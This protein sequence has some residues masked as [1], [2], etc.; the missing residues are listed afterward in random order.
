[1]PRS[2]LGPLAI[3][4][5]LGDH[6]SQSSV[7]RAIH[8]EQKRPIAVKIFA[9]PF[10]GTL[11]SRTQ[12]A[13]EWD[14]LKSLSHPAIVRCYG[15]GFEKTDAYLAHELIEGETLSAELQR[16]TR[17]SWESVLEIAEPI[18]DALEY[19]H[20][21]GIVH[22]AIGPEKIMIAGLSPLLLDVRTDRFAS[23]FRTS[24]PPTPLEVA[25]QPPQR[26]DDPNHATVQGDLYSLG[27]TLYLAVTGRPPISGD[28]LEEIRDNVRSEVPTSAASIAMDCPVWLS[29]LISQLLSK[30][31]AARP[32]GAAAVKL[33]LGE[34]RRRSMSRAG[35]A[36]HASSGFSPLSVT[37]QSE[38]D[39]ARTLLGRE[40]V[41]VDDEEAPDATPWHDKPW[42][43]IAAL[44]VIV[45]LVTYTMW[46]LSE[47]ALRA[48]AEGL[49][50]EESRSS[51][52]EAKLKF[53]QPMLKRYP[54]GQHAEWGQDQIDRVDV[55]LFLHNLSVKKKNNL[56][57]TNEGE[58][59]HRE[60]L[61]YQEVGDHAAALD[62]YRSIV[63]VLGEDAQYRVA[64][65]AARKRIAEIES[66]GTSKTE[67]A[68]IVQSKLDEAERLLDEGQVVEAKKIWYS[69]IDLYGNN[70]ELAPLVAKAQSRLAAQQPVQ[71][72]P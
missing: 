27:A 37:D 42:F 10:G 62:K 21:K 35:V 72:T 64:V 60:A 16:R 66:R 4:S 7:W 23:V 30:D 33:A 11:E 55:E 25:L 63:T 53:L 70:S 19:L 31:P 39:E 5:K 15:G 34:V 61:R 52:T 18:A 26:L 8:I 17:L 3:E 45:A 41:N 2:R 68:Q 29:K 24:R 51:W 36:E 43:L 38:R 69:L 13:E 67:A 48:K 56:R 12:F 46:P 32:A 71:A 58:R 65:N 20:G 22:G 40:L 14:V 59:L 50:Q 1:M 28:T 44:A 57:L 54:D 6:P 49:L 9:V 47:D